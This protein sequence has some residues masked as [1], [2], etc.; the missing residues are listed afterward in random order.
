MKMN[1][2]TATFAT[3]RLEP[4]NDVR[5]GLEDPDGNEGLVIRIT[6]EDFGKMASEYLRRMKGKE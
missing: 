1:V 4:N 3:V 2:E 5:I 6:A